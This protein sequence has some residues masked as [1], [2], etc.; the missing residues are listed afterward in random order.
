MTDNMRLGIR[1][2]LYLTPVA[3]LLALPTLSFSIRVASIVNG[4]GYWVYWVQ[5][6]IPLFLL[7]LIGG[8]AR[9]RGYGPGTTGLWAGIVYGLIAGACLC[10][11]AVLAPRKPALADAVWN[12]YLARGYIG[13]P[14]AH[15][16]VRTSVLHPSVLAFVSR[17]AFEF[18]IVGL[19]AAFIG[20]LFVKGAGVSPPPSDA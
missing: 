5:N 12:A 14:A 6:L 20:G 16:A 1:L 15:N 3:I 10:G 17:T 8:L 9:R 19:I 2:G 18:A 7:A 11:V 4:A 13:T